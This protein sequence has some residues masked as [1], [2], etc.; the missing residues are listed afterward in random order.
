MLLS[1]VVG[2]SSLIFFTATSRRTELQSFSRTQYEA[3][4]YESMAE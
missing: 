1:R 4:D 3:E 2:L